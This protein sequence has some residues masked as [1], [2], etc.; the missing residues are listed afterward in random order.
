MLYLSV[1]L[2]DV[3]SAQQDL[4]VLQNGKY[5]YSLKLN[6]ERRVKFIIKKSR[7]SS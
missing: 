2:D 6:R 1:K 5:F 4:I 7:L 3:A